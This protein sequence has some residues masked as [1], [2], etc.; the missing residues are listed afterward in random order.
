MIL[1]D[2]SGLSDNFKFSRLNAFLRTPCPSAVPCTL[3]VFDWSISAC[4]SANSSSTALDANP[5]L[6]QTHWRRHAWKHLAAMHRCDEHM[7]PR[8]SRSHGLAEY[9]RTRMRRSHHIPRHM[10][11]NWVWPQQRTALP[12]PR[13]RT[14]DEPPPR[15]PRTHVASKTCSSSLAATFDQFDAHKHVDQLFQ[16]VGPHECCACGRA[17]T[18]GC[19]LHARSGRLHRAAECFVAGPDVPYCRRHQRQ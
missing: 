1:L 10:H 17:A 5:T 19:T 9:L 18:R 7:L 16:L 14:H 2:T 11:R 13:A 8:G 6:A 4:T 12:K 15:E 3:A